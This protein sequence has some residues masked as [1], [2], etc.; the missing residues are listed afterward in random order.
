MKKFISLFL[1]FSILALSGNAFAKDRKGADVI[2]QKAD[3]TQV[4]GELLAVKEN[5]LLLLDTGAG[6]SVDIADI[7][8]IRIVNKSKFW[9]GFTP[10]F[11]GAGAIGTTGV[12]LAAERDQ[13]EQAAVAFFIFGFLGA[14]LGG[15]I[16]SIVLE[17]DTIQIEGKS[18]SEI[19]EILEK[20]HKKAR[21]KNYQ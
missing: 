19:Q 10:G 15:G 14:L 12:A 9:K 20:L 8:A 17:D 7:I 1:V 6:I 11:L 4:K 13:R 16:S 2:I 5:S 3:D 21:V 18:D